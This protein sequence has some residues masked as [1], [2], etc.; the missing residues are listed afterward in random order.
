MCLTIW[1]SFKLKQRYVKYSLL[2]QKNL[3]PWFTSKN[4]PVYSYLAITYFFRF[5]ITHRFWWLIGTEQQNK[6]LHYYSS[7][8]LLHISKHDLHSWKTIDNFACIKLKRNFPYKLHT[9]GLKNTSFLQSGKK[10]CSLVSPYCIFSS[11]FSKYFT[12]F[13][14]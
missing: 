6:T 13:K 10:S 14:I 1:F 12:F 3:C 9:L 4:C 11:H 2:I 8:S 5:S 7:K